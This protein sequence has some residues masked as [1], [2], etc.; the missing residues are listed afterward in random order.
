MNSK[1]VVLV[2][3]GYAGILA[4]LRTRRKDPQLRVTLVAPSDTFVE[5]IRLYELASTGRPVSH[6]IRR[7]LGDGV[8]FHQALAQR[9]DV[10]RAIL[11]TST[12]PLHYDA[13]IVATGSHTRT[14]TVTGVKEFATAVEYGEVQRLSARLGG[15]SE[16]KRILVC[17]GGLT[18]IECATS[19][20]AHR[21]HH[22]TLVAQGLVGPDLSNQ[23]RRFVRETLRRLN[24]DLRENTPVQQLERGRV[25]LENEQLTFD[26]CIW[27][28]GM[29]GASL[30][31]DSGL[32]VNTLQQVLIDANLNPVAA[33]C[34]N[35]F[36]AGDAGSFTLGH[37]HSLSMGCKT[38]LP[39]GAHAADNAVA[40]LRGKPVEPFSFRET[41]SCLSLG[42]SG[43]V[44]FLERDG[45]PRPQTWHGWPASMLKRALNRF[46]L[47]ALWGEKRGIGYRWLTLP[48]QPSTTEI[49]T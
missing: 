5:R 16:G 40:F 27:A 28:C 35:V 1:Q 33:H 11:E 37:G 30:A 49:S 25:A 4:A 22:V 32:P 26:E 46:T 10:R 41:L 39:L 45:T 43:L 6:P 19:L 7:F 18:A 31:K 20:A 12:G 47:M 13:L 44:Q 15:H 23:G 9:I 34:G 8:H 48:A 17:G 42:P 14:N 21:K 3:G 2:G 36:A 38:A 24:V 29:E